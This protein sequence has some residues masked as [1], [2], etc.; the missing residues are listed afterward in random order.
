[1]SER[2]DLLTRW[3][4]EQRPTKLL[5]LVRILLAGLILKNS[6]RLLQEL[7]RDGYFASHFFLPVVPESW[8]PPVEVYQLLVGLK[9]I[10]A[11]LAIVGVLPRASLFTAAAVGLYII[12]CDR[13]HY[14][15]NHYATHLLALLLSWAPCGD[16]FNLANL[17]LRRKPA[18]LG[19][20]WAVRLTQLQVSV[21]YLASGLG[22]LLDGDWRGGR[23]MSLRFAKAAHGAPELLGEILRSPLFG[24]LASKA[25]I[26]T[27]LFV[28]IGLWFSRTRPAALWLGILFHVGIQASA[29]VD[30][31]SYLMLSTYIL[32]V[33]P[34]LRQRVLRVDDGRKK[35][36]AVARVVRLL[37]WFQRFRIETGRPADASAAFSVVERDGRVASRFAGV[38]ALCRALP[39]LFPLW[40][41]LRIAL[42]A[43]EGRALG[44]S[45]TRAKPPAPNL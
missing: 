17:L 35:G 44:S 2:D 38:V 9:G 20:Y 11:L 24:E 30:L 37:D 21:V 18:A 7:A 45:A 34:E 26:F 6:F 40:L 4:R 33:T 16:G 36:Q 19:P 1:M 15:N 28:G 3:A 27:E 14:H 41:P 25:A 12:A 39:L 10:A 43:S 5:G 22:K 31:F 8:V 23:A 13:L 32:F 42:L 29:R